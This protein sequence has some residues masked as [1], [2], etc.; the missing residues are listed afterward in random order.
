MRDIHQYFNF[1]EGVLRA[2]GAVVEEIDFIPW[3]PTDVV[4][5]GAVYFYDGGRLEFS[6]EVAIEQTKP[7]KLNYRSVYSRGKGCVSV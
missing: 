7:V 3:G 2:S 1:I 5:D 4:I 6:E